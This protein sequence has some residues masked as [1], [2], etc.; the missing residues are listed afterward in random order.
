MISD[1]ISD[2]IPPQI[3]IFNMFIVIFMHI[4]PC[5]PLNLY[6]V[7]KWNVAKA[8]CYSTKSDVIN[9]VKYF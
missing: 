3:N 8:A 7:S 6:L 5:L 4:C 9:N 1:H 2:N